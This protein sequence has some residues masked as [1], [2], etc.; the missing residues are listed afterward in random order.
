MPLKFPRPFPRLD[1]NG[2]GQLRLKC[3]FSP[4]L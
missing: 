2:L 4:Q 1:L 3:P